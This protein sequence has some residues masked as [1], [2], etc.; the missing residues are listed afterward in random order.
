M[1]N[2][3]TDSREFHARLPRDGSVNVRDDDL[4]VPAPEIDCA[5]AAAGTLILGGDAEHN[6]IR[7]LLQLQTHL[8]TQSIQKGQPPFFSRGLVQCAT[9]H[10]RTKAQQESLP[11]EGLTTHQFL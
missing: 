5:V 11:V 7:T 1:L 9:C 3:G 2:S 10:V 6:V 4:V 8:S